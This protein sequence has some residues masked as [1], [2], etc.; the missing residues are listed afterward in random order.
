M[1]RIAQLAS[2]S[3]KYDRLIRGVEWDQV[4][5]KKLL[6]LAKKLLRWY[7]TDNLNKDSDFLILFSERFYSKSR[8]VRSAG[9]RMRDARHASGKTRN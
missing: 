8:C 1:P 9:S 6:Y 5:V 2:A 4:L 3:P 7:P